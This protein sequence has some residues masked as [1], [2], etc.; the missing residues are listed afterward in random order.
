MI[1]YTILRVYKN[2]NTEKVYLLERDNFGNKDKRSD[3]A[4]VTETFSKMTVFKDLYTA[5]DM[6]SLAVDKGYLKCFKI[7]KKTVISD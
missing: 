1:V 7:L 4:L 6:L 2:G 5:L 3:T